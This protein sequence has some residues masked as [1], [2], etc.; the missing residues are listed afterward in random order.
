MPEAAVTTVVRDGRPPVVLVHGL[1][2]IMR[3]LLRSPLGRLAKPFALL[4]FTGRRSGRRYRVPVGWHHVNGMTIVF[5]P[6]PWR[7]NFSG[8]A[9]VVVHHGGRVHRMTG[10][11]VSDPNEVVAALRA[12]LA[13]GRSAGLVGLNVPT[14]HTVTASEVTKLDRAMVRFA[15][16]G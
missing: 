2:V 13:S 5:T 3:P 16:S 10:M 4:E 15:H 14:G 1:N 6:A 12:V 11:L 8:G 9:P 7:A